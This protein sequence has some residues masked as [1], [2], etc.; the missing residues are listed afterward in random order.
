MTTINARD[1]RLLSCS[2]FGVFEAES[3]GD[4]ADMGADSGDQSR[5]PLIDSCDAW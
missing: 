4:T 1:F 3:G 2:L 5:K